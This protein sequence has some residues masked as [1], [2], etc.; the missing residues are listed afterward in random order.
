MITEEIKHRVEVGV[1]LEKSGYFSMVMAIEY[2]T[3]VARSK[4]VR[5]EELKKYHAIAHKQI[6]MNIS[7]IHVELKK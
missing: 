5:L 1:L 3:A 4:N 6:N 2:L 7:D